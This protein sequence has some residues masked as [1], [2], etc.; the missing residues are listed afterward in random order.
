MIRSS[1]GA[2]PQRQQ[3][4]RKTFDLVISAQNGQTAQMREKHMYNLCLASPSFCSMEKKILGSLKAV[5]RRT[6]GR[7]CVRG[8]VYQYSCLSDLLFWSAYSA[9]A[10][11][12]QVTNLFMDRSFLTPS[13]K[14]QSTHE[15]VSLVSV[16]SCCR[17]KM[18]DEPINEL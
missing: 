3:R 4:E 10:F 7:A 2:G 5:C 13:S 14:T 16:D 11:P 18:I 17:S 6:H 12:K 1:C 9:S 8:R 15:Y